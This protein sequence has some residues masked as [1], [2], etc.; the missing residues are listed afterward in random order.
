MRT[1]RSSVVLSIF[2]RFLRDVKAATPPVRISL[3][4]S[5]PAAPSLVEIM[6]VSCRALPHFCFAIDARYSE[7]VA[8]ENPDAF[9]PL[10]DTLTD[11][12]SHLMGQGLTHEAIYHSAIATAVAHEH[13]PDSG[14]LAAVEMGLALHSAAP[15]I[16][17][18]YQHYINLHGGKSDRG[19][20]SWVDWYG[21]TVCDAERLKQ[22]AGVETIDSGNNVLPH[23]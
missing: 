3:R 2:L 21:E 11:P 17:A 19:C 20:G 13:I 14:S 12:A 23:L 9:F 18:F 6:C 5:W 4:S 15:K 10:L 1:L 22:L 8:L 16:E 7:T